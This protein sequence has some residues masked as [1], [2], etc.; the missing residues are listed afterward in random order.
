M[1][2]HAKFHPERWID[3]IVTIRQFM[4]DLYRALHSFYGTRE[5]G[6][7]VVAGGINH[8]ATM[9]PHFRADDLTAELYLTEC[10]D[11]VFAHHP[12]VSVN[13][14]AQDGG[15]P[16]ISVATFFH[17][18]SRREYPGSRVFCYTSIVTGH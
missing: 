11:F 6:E 17:F 15:Q 3:T 12:A 4:L 8:A 16:P 13:V 5:L 18:W 1:N 7:D 10:G 2:A 9:V 14:G